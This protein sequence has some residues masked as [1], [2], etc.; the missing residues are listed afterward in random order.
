MIN[1]QTKCEMRTKAACTIL[2]LFEI[3]VFMSVRLDCLPS[4]IGLIVNELS[5][6]VLLYTDEMLESYVIK[7][8]F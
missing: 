8:I 3:H 5:V 6:G 7:C 2:A 1:K 4:R